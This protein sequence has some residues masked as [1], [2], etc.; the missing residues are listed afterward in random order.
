MIGRKSQA[1]INFAEY[2]DIF[3]FVLLCDTALHFAPRFSL[4]LAQRLHS[5]SATLELTR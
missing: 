3:A 2:M 1:P 5:L 4:Q